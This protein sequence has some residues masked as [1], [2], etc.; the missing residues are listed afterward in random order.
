M[1]QR[2]L[3]SIYAAACSVIA[4]AGAGAAFAGDVC[5]KASDKGH[6]LVEAKNWE[7]NG[8]APEYWRWCPSMT[9][10]SLGHVPSAPDSVNRYGSLADG[11]QL[12]ATGFF[13]IAKHKG[14]WIMVDPDG[15]IHI[16][17]AVVG[18][19]SG[20]GER[21]RA[22]FARLYPLGKEQWITQAAKELRGY[23]FNGAGAWSD[24]DNI[25]LFN[26]FFSDGGFTYCPIFD[27]MSDYA[28][29]IGVA[30][31][32]PGN[33]AYPN[34]CIRVFDPGFRQYCEKRIPE[35]VARYKDDPNVLGYFSD[36]E[37]PLLAGNLKGYLALPEDD[38][39]HKAAERWLAGKGLSQSDISS[40]VSR[41]FAGY[42][43]DT[44]FGIVSEILK[45]AD[46]N[47]LYL[48]C[49]FAG[50]S[51]YIEGIWKAAA[52]WCDV[53]SV[54]YYGQWEVL[55]SDI[56]RWESWADAP[57]MV[58]EF[59]T[60]GEDSGLPNKTGAGWLVHTQRDRGIHYENFVIGLLRSRT[61]VGWSW[62][63]YQDN[64]P[65][66]RNAESS[67]IDSNKGL[68]DNSYTPYAPLVESMRKANTIRYSILLN[69]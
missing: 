40:E 22:N 29:S 10:D 66:S 51:K 41:E 68:V 33:T 32:N 24:E 65:S 50:N 9:V 37:M 35:F 63:K 53:I 38:W 46:P 54:N 4:F 58:T 56:A 15:R 21:Q 47:H 19:V 8:E 13:R 64:D 36:N 61:C 48:G 31:H 45:K 49:R 42:V 52:K 1:S 59:Y 12:E 20:S 60:K 25:R 17:A 69:L 26:D 23:G 55:E 14:R 39:G 27:V 3:V 6:I 34:R 67:N 57:F 5:P 11:P 30:S 28:Y 43:A 16:D 2:R 18:L 62:L 44:Y 7:W